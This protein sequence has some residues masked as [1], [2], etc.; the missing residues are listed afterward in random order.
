MYSW[1]PVESVVF[2][3]ICQYM[4]TYICGAVAILESRI[5]WMEVGY[6]PP[7]LEFFKSCEGFQS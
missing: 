3:L 4:K 2:I 1:W 5:M 7:S 6:A